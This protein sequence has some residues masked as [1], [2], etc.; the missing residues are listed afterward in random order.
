MSSKHHGSITLES[1]FRIYSRIHED[2]PPFQFIFHFLSFQL[3][4]GQNGVFGVTVI[5]LEYNIDTVSAGIMHMD[6]MA[7]AIYLNHVMA[8][9]QSPVIPWLVSTL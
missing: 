1:L 2:P 7:I 3:E 5:V 8:P 6:V 4:G 9:C